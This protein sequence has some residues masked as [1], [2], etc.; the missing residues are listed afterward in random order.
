M[1][2]TRIIFG[3]LLTLAVFGILLADAFLASI[4][5]GAENQTVV[6][7]LLAHGGPSALLILALALAAVAE[8]S[9]LV[10]RNEL[11]SLWLWPALIAGALVTIP[12]WVRCLES[13][14]AVQ[15]WLDM[16]LTLLVLILGIL[17][18]GLG[19]ILRRS[20]NNGLGDFAGVVLTIV[21]VGFFTGFAVRL[22]QLLPGSE[23]S[24]LLLTWVLVVK[25][26]DV[27]AFFTGLLVGKRPLVPTIS[28][29]K[30]IEGFIG[31]TAVGVLMGL[32]AW[33]AI[34]AMRP[35]FQNHGLHPLLYLLVFAA[36]MSLV[37]Q[38]GDL[39]ESV[40]KR[41]AQVKDSG[42]LIPTFG[43]VLDVL[44]SLI[45]SAPLAWLMLSPWNPHG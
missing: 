45:L 8:F 26:T 35:A 1:V 17:G 15:D 31:G 18:A 12:W 27:G 33:S 34:P 14:A 11:R 13:A 41:S 23:G 36:V 25:F 20:A 4:W 38:V 7:T 40:I 42:A 6:R 43:G 9:R 44:D 2:K 22:R 24:W 21:Y 32:L 10:A 28:P 19:L 29:N 30:T 16:K 3:T 5:Q 39:L 37:G